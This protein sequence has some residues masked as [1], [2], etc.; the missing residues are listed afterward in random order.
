MKSIHAAFLEGGEIGLRRGGHELLVDLGFFVFGVLDDLLAL[1][2]T[3]FD[4]AFFRQ[5]RV[6]FRGFLAAVQLCAQAR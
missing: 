6:A 4:A 2:Q 5:K 3:A 1:G